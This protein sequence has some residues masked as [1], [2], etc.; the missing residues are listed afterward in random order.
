[1][2]IKGLDYNTGR[3]KLIM[4]EYGREIQK[5]VDF[6]VSLPSKEERLKCAKTIVRMMLTKV[7]QIC[8]NAGYEQTL[9]DHLYIMS[10]KQL[11]IDWPFDVTSA[12]KIHS[13]PEP[14]PLPQKR[15]RL[16]HYGKLVDEL[17]GKLKTMPDGEER[18]ELIRQTANQMKRDLLTW[19][20]G[21]A[22]DEKVADDMARLTDGAVQIDLNKFR[23]EKVTAI[24]TDEG[25]KGRRKK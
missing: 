22:D 3:E 1:M 24:A 8:D 25:R 21:S 19:G 6:A 9:W 5:M 14:I 2:D 7:P 15:I 16:R 4:P 10:D 12:E 13:K 20:H 11:D 18:T 17:L 23:F